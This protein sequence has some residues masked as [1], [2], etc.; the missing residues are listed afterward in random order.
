MTDNEVLLKQAEGVA[1]RRRVLLVINAATYAA[2]VGVF[3]V[4]VS[5]IHY[6]FPFW[7]VAAAVAC[8]V[9]W[10]LS[11]IAILSGIRSLKRNRALAGLV[12]D[13]R[14]CAVTARS[15]QAGFWV[16]LAAIAILYAVAGFVPLNIR[17]VLPALIALGVAV[18]N[19]TYAWLYRN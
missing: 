18:P 5:G 11:M 10:V 7:A 15:H 3:A 17:L 12:D 14:T 16:L 4:S 6:V 13:E 9:V 19:L 8:A 1:V 2:W